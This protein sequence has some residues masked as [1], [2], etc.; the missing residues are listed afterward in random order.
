VMSERERMGKRCGNLQGD[1]EDSHLGLKWRPVRAWVCL[2]REGKNLNLFQGYCYRG[3][4]GK[5]MW[6]ML[7]RIVV[8]A[9]RR[10]G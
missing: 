9:R 6:K 10:Q 2:V 8:V 5:H 1:D 3:P 7:Q 4:Y